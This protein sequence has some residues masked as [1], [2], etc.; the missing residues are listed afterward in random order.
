MKEVWIGLAD[1]APYA[2]NNILGSAK[3]AY[4]NVV[5]MAE[6][7]SAFQE[8]ATLALDRI[9]LFVKSFGNVQSKSHYFE[10]H[11]SSDEFAEIFADAEKD[12]A[13]HFHTFH[14]YKDDETM[15]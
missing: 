10:T 11:S 2:G 4:V 14:S 12:E 15:N 6:S 7:R 3:G 5:V 9:G 13:V 8:A 1:V